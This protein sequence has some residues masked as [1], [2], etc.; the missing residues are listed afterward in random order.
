MDGL[1]SYPDTQAEHP[2]HPG[3][4]LFS[5]AARVVLYRAHEEAQGLKRNCIGTEHL[6]LA[7]LNKPI[8]VEIKTLCLLLEINVEFLRGAMR[9]ILSSETPIGRNAN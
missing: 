9:R 7:L 8:T 4:E 1:L 5:Q 2:S 6:L 3:L